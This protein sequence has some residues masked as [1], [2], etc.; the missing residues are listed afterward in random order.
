MIASAQIRASGSFSLAITPD[1]QRLPDHAML[2]RPAMA[3]E[4]ITQ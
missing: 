1:G 3:A 4:K 2:I